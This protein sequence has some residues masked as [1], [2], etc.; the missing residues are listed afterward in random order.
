[1]LTRTL[2]PFSETWPKAGSMLVGAC[3]R[4]RS[5]ERRISEIGCGPWPTAAAIDGNPPTGGDLYQTK[6]G[7]VRARNADGTTSN[8]G[9]AAVVRW[10][11]PSASDGKDS[12]RDGFSPLGRAFKPH[13]F[14]GG[15]KTRRK[16]PT[17]TCD[18][19]S[20]PVSNR[21]PNQMAMLRR[22][23]DQ[24]GS[25]SGQLNPYWVEWLMGFPIG[26][27]ALEPLAMRKFRRWLELHGIC[28]Q[29][30]ECAFG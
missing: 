8:R 2:E 7:T 15:P 10:P 19:A 4:R 9:L 22:S 27:T 11:T 14:R 23:K 26:W 30:T 17:P 25:G 18:D 6:S 13:P 28:S 16:W 20:A 1:L 24:P 3:Y 5:A 21:K 29:E 12:E